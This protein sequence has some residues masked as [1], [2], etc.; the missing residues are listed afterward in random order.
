[1]IIIKDKQL[2][3]GCEACEQVCPQKCIIMKQDKEGFLYPEVNQMSCISCGRCDTVCPINEKSSEDRS[4]PI[5]YGGWHKDNDI[6]S[7]SSSGAAFTLFAEYILRRGGIVYGC[8]L[9]EDMEA[10]HVG[11]ESM[12]E[13]YKLRGSKYVQSRINGVYEQIRTYLQNGRSILFVGTPCQAAGLH[14]F[15]GNSYENLYVIDFI[16]HG[17]PSPKLFRA[18]IDDIEQ[19]HGKKVTAYKFRNK[20][21]GWNQTGIQLGT[22]I[23]FQNG[24]DIRNYP[25]FRD[26]Y[27]NAFLDNV[28]LRPSCYMCG[29]KDAV[30][31]YADFTIADFWGVNHV[32]KK[33]NDGKGTS[34]ILVHNSRANELWEEVSKNFYYEQVDFQQAICRNRSL[35]QSAGLNNNRNR[36]YEELDEKGYRYVKY[37]Y[38]L[39]LT[40][41]IH[42][43]MGMLKHKF[44]K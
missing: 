10:V 33:L 9:N 38:M 15:L 27:M 24:T 26:H 36:F 3:C 6:R 7:D 17:V 12:D 11:I 30:K 42:K 23:S 5:A 4:E 29:F 43:V 25:A 8:M 1:M 16:C 19:K 39:A 41:G 2:C 20:D 13:L 34:L 35:I 32:S 44:R 22:K 14:S 18:Y 31:Y 40:W 21:H 28:C 37:K